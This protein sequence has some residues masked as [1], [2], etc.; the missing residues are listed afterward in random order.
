MG[1]PLSSPPALDPATSTPEQE[2]QALQGKGV[3]GAY[4]R[5]LDAWIAK[6][7]SEQARNF[8]AKQSQWPDTF[9]M[10]R[11]VFNRG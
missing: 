9:G 2:K 8:I 4:V 7:G 11:T 3:L 6:A 5:I 1:R 10:A